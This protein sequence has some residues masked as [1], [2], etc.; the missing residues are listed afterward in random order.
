VERLGH[1]HRFLAGSGVRDQ[2]CLVGRDALRDASNLVHQ[3]VVD[4]QSA[5]GVEDHVTV[6]LGAGARHAVDGDIQRRGAGAF[7][8]NRQI[9]LPRERDQ[10]IDRGGPLS[11]RRH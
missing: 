6:A 11:V 8:V 9:D 3:R 5:G 10:L 1:G 4:L 7:L 2:Q